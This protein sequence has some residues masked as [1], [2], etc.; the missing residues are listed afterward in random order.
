MTDESIRAYAN[1]FNYYLSSRESIDR[2]IK[3][4]LIDLSEQCNK[5]ISPGIR[6]YTGLD[7]IFMPYYHPDGTPELHLIVH[8]PEDDIP[9][10][11][12]QEDESTTLELPFRIIHTENKIKEYIKRN[13]P[14]LL[15]IANNFWISICGDPAYNHHLKMWEGYKVLR[16]YKHG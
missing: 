15:S 8:Y 3:D 4:V 12:N 2:Q 7:N 16:R 5:I 13:Y 14:E 11:N 9:N 6:E 10:V 1:I